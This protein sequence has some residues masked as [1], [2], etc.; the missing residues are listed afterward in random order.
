MLIGHAIEVRHIANC[1][2]ILIAAMENHYYGQFAAAIVG[3]RQVH[4]ILSIS[5][6]AIASFLEY[7]LDVAS[8]LV[9]IVNRAVKLFR[10]CAE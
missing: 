5:R 6:A 10:A 1:V 9:V 8:A 2:V 3:R 4:Q 7:V